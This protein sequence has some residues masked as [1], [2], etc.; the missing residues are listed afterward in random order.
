ML[1]ETVLPTVPQPLPNTM[2]L[3]TY[4]HQDVETTGDRFDMKVLRC[5]H[6]R[7]DPT[8]EEIATVGISRNGKE[9]QIASQRSYK[10]GHTKVVNNNGTKLM[11]T[12]AVQ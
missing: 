3:G 4:R 8:G 1:Q 12:R 11:K 6:K 9:R 5:I 2:N 10:N 7:L